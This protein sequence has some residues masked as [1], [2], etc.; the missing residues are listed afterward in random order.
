MHP[1]LARA[2]RLLSAGIVA[3]V[4]LT[5]C[6][7]AGGDS[8]APPGQAGPARYVG[9]QTADSEPVD[10]GLLTFGSYSFPNTLDPAKTQATGPTGGTEMGAI[11]DTLTRYDPES[12]AFVPQLAESLDVN[13]DLTIFTIT[14]PDG[15]T[16]SDGS[17][18]DA[19]SVKWSIDRFV[20]AKGDMSQHWTN[21]VESITTAAAQ[22][23]EFQLKR[24]WQDFPA[25]L[26]TGPGMIVGAGSEKDGAFT[27]I[28]AGPFT[29]T[30]FAPSEELL[31]TS[32]AD[33]V[34]GKPHLDT[35]RFLPTS[36]A[37]A[38]YESLRSG[39]FDMT[40]IL[41]DE[42]VI[43][44][45]Q[46]DGYSG[47]LS[48]SGQNGIG[49]I[50]NRPGRPGADIRVRQAIA[51]GVDP[52][53]I[54]QRVNAGLG[55]S[56]YELIP[57]SSRWN[58]GTPGIEFDPDRARAL[59]EE[60]KADGYDGKISYLSTHDPSQQATALTVQAGL[61]SVG[62][63]VTI[64]YAADTTELV[65]KV[66][67]E[68]DFDLTRGGAPISDEAPFLNLYSSMGSDSRNNA[69]GFSDSEMDRLLLDVQTAPTD[70]AKRDAISQVQLYAN[71]TVPYAIWGPASVLTAWSPAVRDV[72]RNITDIMLF[73]K[74]WIST[75]S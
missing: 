32:R 10:G 18:L 52:D 24:P 57:E 29:L 53:A 74:A 67:A 64:E 30:K 62:F 14:L 70:D 44:Q 12:Q 54:N 3:A 63:D 2:T 13:D 15:A 16:F 5:A 9:I 51:Y 75:T 69:T 7:S 65:R 46:D 36:G 21:I 23:V 60:A 11:Y 48:P 6:S 31:L 22:T 4:L 1:P 8:A 49:T 71:E 72:K 41:R 38:Q 34:G 59:L 25:L 55:M 33:Y 27:P 40:Y 19:Q 43:S 26:S 50:N 58:N 20:A 35:L 37:Q 47:F 28:G 68:H 17:V 45:A 61:N 42:Q 56:S 73:D 66:Y 39:Q